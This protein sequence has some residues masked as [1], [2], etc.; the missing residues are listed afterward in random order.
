[1]PIACFVSEKRTVT[2][3]I[4]LLLLFHHHHQGVKEKEIESQRAF[5][6][7]F[8]F[9][10]WE[11]VEWLFSF[12]GW[13]AG[14]REFLWLRL[15]R[16][17]RG[18]REGRGGRGDN[19]CAKI[20][21]AVLLLSCFWVRYREVRAGGFSGSFATY[22]RYPSSWRGHVFFELRTIYT[23]NKKF[24][25]ADHPPRHEMTTW[26]SRPLFFSIVRFGRMTPGDFYPFSAYERS[27]SFGVGS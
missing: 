22:L 27:L 24:G 16:V 2:L 15:R 21:L 10:R 20:N 18:T 14:R 26:R 4:I 13:P 3:T 8:S 25:N 12:Q 19:L 23:N 1:M 5:F 6:L 17:T 9:L 11:D 7:L